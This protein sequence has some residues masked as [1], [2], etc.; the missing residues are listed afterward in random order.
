MLPSTT[1]SQPVPRR[2]NPIAAAL[3]LLLLLLS[4]SSS[5]LWSFMDLSADHDVSLFWSGRRCHVS[6]DSHRRFHTVQHRELKGAGLKGQMHADVVNTTGSY[7]QSCF[8]H[9]AL[10]FLSV[11]THI[12]ISTYH[13][14][15]SPSRSTSTSINPKETFPLTAD[16]PENHLVLSFLQ[17][18]SNLLDS[19]NNPVIFVS[20]SMKTNRSCRQLDHTGC[21][22]MQDKSCI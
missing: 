17:S 11:I 19:Q 1:V 9:S 7:S 14:K 3:L 21:K 22:R 13:Q 6:P 20:T 12:V 8:K 5:L 4:L 18:Q 16:V 15:S 10:F 2:G